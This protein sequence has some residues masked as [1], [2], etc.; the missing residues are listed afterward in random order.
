MEIRDTYKVNW[1]KSFVFFSPGTKLCFTVQEKEIVFK[2][3]LLNIVTSNSNLKHWV[4]EEISNDLTYY[5]N[6]TSKS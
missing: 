4:L 3:F 2:L 1:R 6:K 5:M